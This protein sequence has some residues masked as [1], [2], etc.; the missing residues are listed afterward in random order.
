MIRRATIERR[1]S[2]EDKMKI[3]GT[4]TIAAV[5]S[6]LASVGCSLQAPAS[7]EAVA[8]EDGTIEEQQ[9]VYDNGWSA[10]ANAPGTWGVSAPKGQA[11]ADFTGSGTRRAG[12]CLLKKTST[13]CNTVADCSGVT[14]APGG[15]RYCT[16]PNL[17]GQKYC[18]VRNGSAASWCGGTP[19]N[20]AQ[21][22][23][24]T[25]Y[26]PAVNVWFG[27]NL[28]SYACFEGCVATD[29]SSSSTSTVVSGNP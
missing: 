2:L 4:A 9:T 14:V 1:T 11:V 27:D 3:F 15:F 28:I 6:L 24:G 10:T 7:D 8:L 17:T 25:V 12:V 22:S 19:A 20:G 29:P 23:A 21:I 26:S 16:S 13:T 18:Y 5:C